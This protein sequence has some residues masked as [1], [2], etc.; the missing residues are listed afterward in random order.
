MSAFCTQAPVAIFN[1]VIAASRD[2]DPVIVADLLD[3][4]SA[5][6]AQYC[7]QT[8]P[9]ADHVTAVARA[10][11]M[12]VDEQQPL[13]LLDDPSRLAPAASVD[14]L[15][16]RRLGV[17]EV[18]QHLAILAEG[19]GAPMELLAPWAGSDLLAVNGVFAYAGSVGGRDVATALGIVVD[20]HVG[21]FNVAVTP[22][23]RR[24]GYGAALS[25]RTVLDGLATGARRA[26]LMSSEMGLEV[27]QRLG[28]RELERW[29]FW[30][31]AELINGE[32]PA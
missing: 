17:E 27:Y 25:A 26:L 23:H 16:I 4:V 21:V 31:P 7:L 24:R 1:G 3:A 11:G 19:F 10:R 15:D 6:I 5:D 13:M 9:G 8:R 22:D 28:F 20:D 18:D 30:V 32:L 12:A 14:G 2:S 29:S